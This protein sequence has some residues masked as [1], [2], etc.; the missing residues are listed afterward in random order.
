MSDS[1]NVTATPPAE[2]PVAAAPLKPAM[3]AKPAPAAK[4]PAKSDAG[5]RI[6]L[7]SAFLIFFG[8]WLAIA[9][10]AL[11]VAVLAMVLGTVRFLFPNVLSEPPSRVKVGFPDQFEDGK[12][13][14]RFKDQ[15]IQGC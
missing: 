4:P 11:T 3:P 8:S 15:N 7:I 10:T 9:W 5:R 6:F 12:V 1:S 2:Q 13:V 14:E